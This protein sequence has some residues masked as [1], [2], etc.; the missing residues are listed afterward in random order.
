MEKLLVSLNRENEQ[1]AAP[2]ISPNTWKS[3]SQ[4]VRHASVLVTEFEFDFECDCERVISSLQLVGVSGHDSKFL[5]HK[6][7]SIRFYFFARS[8][9]F[10]HP[11]D[12]CI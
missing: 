5:A 12:I 9:T 7:T 10:Q 1:L 11:Q 4:S 8:D 2:L 3:I 6:K